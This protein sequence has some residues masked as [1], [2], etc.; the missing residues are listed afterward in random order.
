MNSAVSSSML[1]SVLF[2]RIILLVLES[3]V[4]MVAPS[5]KNSICNNSGW[6]W[7]RS[8]PGNFV[9]MPSLLAL[10]N[11]NRLLLVLGL[12]DTTLTLIMMLLLPTDIDSGHSARTA[13]SFGWCCSALASSSWAFLGAWKLIC[14]NAKSPPPPP[15][16]AIA[17]ASAACVSCAAFRA[18]SA[19]AT[20][21]RACASWT[22]ALDPGDE[23]CAKRAAGGAGR[24]KAA[25]GGEKTTFFVALL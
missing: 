10:S 13:L 22:W 21:A 2:N 14:S 16:A 6:M 18:A 17:A 25:G 7:I 1:Q 11:T 12:S 15:T 8:C 20:W 3:L 4:S 9:N 19:A 24:G 23:D 5:G